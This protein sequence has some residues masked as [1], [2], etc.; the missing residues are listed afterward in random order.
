[1][2]RLL[3]TVAVS[4]L[5]LGGAVSGVLAADNTSTKS[6]SGQT[7]SS[8]AAGTTAPSNQTTSSGSAGTTAGA[9]TGASG[10]AAASATTPTDQ[11]AA[12]KK[13]PKKKSQKTS[14]V[15]RDH[16]ADRMANELNRQELAKI[17]GASATSYSSTGTAAPTGTRQ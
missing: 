15:G 2:N 10:Q 3:M 8:G 11:Q 7:M 9:S 17:Q 4:G 6:T 5:V 14:S 12:T 16:S 1:M 13:A